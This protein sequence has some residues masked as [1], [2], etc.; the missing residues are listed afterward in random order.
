MSYADSRAHR[1]L[2]T[3]DRF[4]PIAMTLMKGALRRIVDL[5]LAPPAEPETAAAAGP[6]NPSPTGKAAGKRKSSSKAA[7]ATN[8]PLLKTAYALCDAIAK[9]SN[10]DLRNAIS[11]L[12]LVLRMGLSGAMQGLE[13][14]A[15]SRKAPG[16]DEADGRGGKRQK[17]AAK[18]GS[19]SLARAGMNTTAQVAQLLSLVTERET[20][21][22]LWHAIGKILWNKRA[23]EEK[24]EADR[25]LSR[26]LAARRG[27]EYPALPGHMMH[28]KRKLS[29]V[30]VEALWG[31][32]STDASAFQLFLHHNLPQFCD[33]IDEAADVLDAYS[34]A[35]AELR[36]AHEGWLSA[37]LSGYYTFLA[38]TRAT[39]L[40]LPSP[41]ARRGQVLRK[42]QF[43][44]VGKRSREFADGLADTHRYLMNKAQPKTAIANDAASSAAYA[45]L[46]S[47]S[48]DVLATQILPMLSKLQILDGERVLRSALPFF[49][50][51]F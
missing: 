33:E 17:T 37:G 3:P 50:M 23:G 32:V 48:N 25:Q 35:D 7:S 24:D 41:V 4:N 29:L 31:K 14:L 45:M 26:E 16:A 15:A 30:D 44:D 20:S 34:H 46:S 28:L 49:L 1:P 9:Q 38:S 39:L 11:S 40:H 42:T 5:A 51:T 21:L 47:S 43:W 19:S 10:G 36:A 22:E 6:S 27:E 18:V 8:D 2:P 12:Q 13:S